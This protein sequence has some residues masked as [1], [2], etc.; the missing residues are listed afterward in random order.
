M[1]LRLLASHCAVTTAAAPVTCSF[2]PLAGGSYT[3][4][5]SATDPAGRLVRTTFYRWAAGPG[6]VPWND[7]SQ[8]K[9]DVIPDKDRYQVGDTATVMFASPFTNA[10][11]WI[12][13][14]REGLIEQRRLRLVS[15]STT[16]KFPITEGY[17][18]NVYVSILVA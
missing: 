11:A 1:A 13:V 5:L 2:T 10:E 18:P 3:V 4:A 6:W 15:G 8:F 17:A 14:E 16:L 9:M 7:E 12:T